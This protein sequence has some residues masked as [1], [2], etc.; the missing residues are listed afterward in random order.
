M[1]YNSV[2]IYYN[3]FKI[4]SISIPNALINSHVQNIKLFT[5]RDRKF[6]FEQ[7]A[8]LKVLLILPQKLIL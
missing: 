2:L 5:I 3:I 4:I 7:E 1:S 8:I 6:R